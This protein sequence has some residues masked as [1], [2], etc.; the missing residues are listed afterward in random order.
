MRGWSSGNWEFVEE[1]STGCHVFAVWSSCLFQMGLC[2][3]IVW[4]LFDCHLVF[5]CMLFGCVWL[6]CGCR[7]VFVW[8]SCGFCIVVMW[9][10]S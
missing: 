1:F 8:L 2:V 5:M 3:F 6:S 9:L 7:V 10:S 4:L